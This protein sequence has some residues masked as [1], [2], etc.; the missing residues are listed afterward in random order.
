MVVLPA[1]VWPTIAAVCPGSIVK[2][3]PFITHSTGIAASSAGVAAAMRAAVSASS[4]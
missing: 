2:E 4:L 3:T 1:P